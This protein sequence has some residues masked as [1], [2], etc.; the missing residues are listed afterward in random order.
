M[1]RVP[2]TTPLFPTLS[3]TSTGARE[4]TL[5]GVREVIRL[6]LQQKDSCRIL[7]SSQSCGD[8]LHRTPRCPHEVAH[9]C[10][11]RYGTTYPS[12]PAMAS[13]VSH[14]EWNSVLCNDR[15][16]NSGAYY[17]AHHSAHLGIDIPIKGGG[18]FLSS[19]FGE[20]LTKCFFPLSWN[21]P[22]HGELTGLTPSINV[23]SF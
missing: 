8:A 9:P 22:R 19:I 20:H 16:P 14:A 23:S 10:H 21:F 17:R 11:G 12:A 1:S 5:V 13:M 7:C 18:S 6:L 15:M 3:F 4:R 2:C